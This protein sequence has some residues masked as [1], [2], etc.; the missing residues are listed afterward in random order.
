[1]DWCKC[2]PKT[3]HKSWHG[4]VVATQAVVTKDVPPYAIVGGI[5]ARVI[6]YRFSE[7]VISE[8]LQLQ[9]WDYLF[10]DFKDME[11]D[12]PVEEF[13]Y[14]LKNEIAAGRLKKYDPQI[15]TG[16]EIIATLE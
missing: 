14:R 5:P 4:G 11:A 3:R 12:I 1:M 15:T 8:L 16:A 7:E 13:I 10:V 6:K 2:G 9:W